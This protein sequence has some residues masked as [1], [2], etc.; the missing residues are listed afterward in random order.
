MYEQK[1]KD[2]KKFAVLNDTNM[3]ELLKAFI[4]D[5]LEGNKIP[6]NIQDRIEKM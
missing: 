6:K 3:S 1:I 2:F 4:D 5:L